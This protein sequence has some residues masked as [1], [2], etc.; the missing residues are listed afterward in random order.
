[1][2]SRTGVDGVVEPPRS[3][4]R[5]LLDVSLVVVKGTVLAG[6]EVVG[7]LHHLGVELVEGAVGDH[8]FDDDEAVAGEGAEGDFE[9][10]GGE[11]SLVHFGD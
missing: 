2:D 1:M 4:G 9:V 3:H 10:G 5:V 6:L 8:V 11:A 7:V